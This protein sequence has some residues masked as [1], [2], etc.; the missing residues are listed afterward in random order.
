[1]VRTKAILLA[2]NY[3]GIIILIIRRT[4]PELKKNHI[5]P[6]MQTL[7]GVPGVR[8][9]ATEHVLKFPNGSQI[10]CG[11]CKCDSD[12]LQYQGNEY[13]IIFLDEAT[14]LREEWITKIVASCRG[15]DNY[16]HRIYYTC[17][18]G[19][20]GHGYI[21]R[22]F[23]DRD[24]KEGEDPDEYVFIQSLVTDNKVLMENDPGY[25]KFLLSLDPK[26]RKA[27][28][29]G[30]WEAFAGS[31][32]ESFRKTPDLMQCQEHGISQEDALEEH[33]WTHVIKPFKTPEH[34]TTYVSYDWG[35]GRPHSFGFW[36]VSD[37]SIGDIPGTMYRVHEWY[38]CTGTPNEGVH[39]TNEE[40]FKYAREVI[41]THPLLKGKKLYGVADPSIWDGSHDAN[42]I[43]AA[44]VAEKYHIYFDKGN[45]ERIAGWMQVRERMKF[46]NE[47]RAML[48]FFDTCKDAIRTMPL[49]MF[50]EHR[51]E[52]LDTTLEDHACDDIRYMCMTR[53]IQPRMIEEKKKPISDPLNM[54]TN[55]KMKVR[56]VY[57]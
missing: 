31:Y 51:V 57:G 44:D 11:Y 32:F 19:G 34:W 55:N 41:D 37:G 14:Q 15:V 4:Y 45:N 20:V 16:P 38:G 52:D 6:L 36:K 48:Y 13:Q 35:F 30:D 33:K 2:F 42:G 39:M 22:I 27:W 21:K 53:P 25:V 17:N 9:N 24:F 54:F 8:Y 56:N 47:G 26:L 28:L 50:D 5:D 3:P 46:D 23:I 29:E 43:S 18:P 49:M 10:I 7:N 12:V 1:M 40:Q